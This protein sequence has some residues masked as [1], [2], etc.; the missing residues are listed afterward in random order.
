MPTLP[1]KGAFEGYL[2]W[3]DI[4]ANLGSAE[5]LPIPATR[6]K[7]SCLAPAGRLVKVETFRPVVLV[8]ALVPVKFGVHPFDRT[9][10]QV[11]FSGSR[12]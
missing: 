7:T 9:L 12:M 8:L 3:S 5:P 10:S 6:R 4:R 2:I 11:N 1:R